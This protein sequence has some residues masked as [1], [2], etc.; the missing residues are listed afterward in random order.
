MNRLYECFLF[1]Y[2]FSS[3]YLS[4]ARRTPS[5]STR[6][7]L[8]RRPAVSLSSTGNPP[9]SSAVST[10]SLVVPAMGDTMAAGLWPGGNKGLRVI[11]INN[12]NKYYIYY[13]R[14][15][16][17]YLM[18]AS[19]IYFFLI[20]RSI[21][22]SHGPSRTCDTGSRLSQGLCVCSALKSRQI[23]AGNNNRI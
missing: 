14:D 12:N 22:F 17:I 18:W 11:N 13:L 23:G 19:N 7:G 5:L 8:S 16:Y 6:S 1:I 2:L 9:M 3:A 21:N 15:I 20:S 10:T 4:R